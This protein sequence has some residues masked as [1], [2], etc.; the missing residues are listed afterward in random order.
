MSGT[1][2]DGTGQGRGA[3]RSQGQARSAARLLTV[4]ALYQIE[5]NGG[6]PDNVILEFLQHRSESM[7]G[8][9]FIAPPEADRALFADL[10]RGV[11]RTREDLDALVG[12][13]LDSGRSVERLEPLLRAILLAGA[14]EL[15]SR[16]DVPM[17]VVISEYVD[18]AD[19]FF[20]AK[21]PGLVN[22]VLD[23]AAHVL[24][25]DELGGAPDGSHGGAA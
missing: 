4:Q 6:T 11:H 15:R 3:A 2:G 20:E 10:V 7:D 1:G 12:A 25:P 5:L 22:A 18:V 19:A 24:R 9:D 14:Y 23:R 13:C 17:R 16:P 8:D 21:E